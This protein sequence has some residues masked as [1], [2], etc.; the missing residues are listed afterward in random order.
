MALGTATERSLCVASGKRRKS[1]VANETLDLGGCRVRVLER[2]EVGYTIQPPNQ[3]AEVRSN[4]VI[5]ET[6]RRG[7]APPLAFGFCSEGRLA[8]ATDW[9]S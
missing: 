3:E 1:G 5:Q 7:F 4:R 9:L 2:R 8:S 6:R